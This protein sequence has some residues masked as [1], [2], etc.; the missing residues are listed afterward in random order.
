MIKLEVEEQDHPAT[1]AT[2]NR[3]SVAKGKA[4]INTDF[5]SH[6]TYKHKKI[7]YWAPRRWRG[8]DLLQLVAKILHAEM[9]C[10][11]L[12]APPDGFRTGIFTVSISA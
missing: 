6:F 11:C 4:A 2:R 7:T 10:F 1:S 8:T 9:A 3:D 5:S 12:A